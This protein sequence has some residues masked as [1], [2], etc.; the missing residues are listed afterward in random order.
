MLKQYQMLQKDFGSESVLPL[1]WSFVRRNS[2]LVKEELH[3]QL[4]KRPL[5]DRVVVIL[6]PELSSACDRFY[7]RIGKPLMGIY[8]PEILEL[9]D[10]WLLQELNDR[11][12]ERRRI[13]S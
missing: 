7:K 10:F 5:M 6:I 1:S 13:T 4:R 9:I 11:C 2:G 3:I 8:P 12:I